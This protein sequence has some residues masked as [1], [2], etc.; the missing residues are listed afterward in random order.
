MSFL[1]AAES[2]TEPAPLTVGEAPARQGWTKYATAVRN[3]VVAVLAPAAFAVVVWWIVGLA[4]HS[5]VGVISTPTGVLHEITSS[6]AVGEPG[7]GRRHEPPPK[8]CCGWAAA[9][10]AGG[11][12]GLLASR[13]TAR[14]GMAWCPSS[15]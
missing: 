5:I 9:V 10:V 7:H 15:R 3:R 4:D 12:T 6:R 14:C 8:R 11:A 13:D 1:A 2:D